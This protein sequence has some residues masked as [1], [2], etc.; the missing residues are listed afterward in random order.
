MLR[1][2]QAENTLDKLR[3]HIITKELF[4][5]NLK[6]RST[7]AKAGKARTTRFAGSVEKRKV[8]M[9]EESYPGAFHAREA[10][11]VGPEKLDDSED[12]TLNPH[13]PQHEV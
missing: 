8:A 9:C 13:N 6:A 1:K 2:R 5:S 7:R 11:E 3:T 12:K 4:D 10:N